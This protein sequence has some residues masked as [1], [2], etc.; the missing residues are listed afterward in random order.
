MGASLAAGSARRSTKRV[1]YAEMALDPSPR[2][3][4]EKKE[5]KGECLDLERYKRYKLMICTT[6]LQILL[7][8]DRTGA[9]KSSWRQR[10]LIQAPSSKTPT[11]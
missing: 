11:Y 5:P 6:D 10:V 9:K 8:I 7:S 1:N 4:R 2:K 3:K